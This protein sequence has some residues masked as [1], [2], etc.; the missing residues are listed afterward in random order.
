VRCDAMIEWSID[1]IVSEGSNGELKWWRR[2]GQEPHWQL[3]K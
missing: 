1:R 2:H 3:G